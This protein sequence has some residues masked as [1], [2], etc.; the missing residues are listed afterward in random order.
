MF[1]SFHQRKND[2]DYL[3]YFLLLI[4]LEALSRIRFLISND[5]YAKSASRVQ[6]KRRIYKK[7]IYKTVTRNNGHLVKFMLRN[8]RQLNQ[9]KNNSIQDGQSY[10]YLSSLTSISIKS[11]SSFALVFFSNLIRFS[12]FT[13]TS[14]PYCL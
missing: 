10:F 7:T 3:N 14:I 8:P 2:L 11:S 1:L 12:S 4:H 13:G 5:I 9:I 6:R